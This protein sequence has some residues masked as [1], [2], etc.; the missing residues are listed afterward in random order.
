MRHPGGDRS[1]AEWIVKM[2]LAWTAV[3]CGSGDH[4][5]NTTIRTKRPDATREYENRMGK[6][7]NDIWPEEDLFVMHRLPFRHGIT[8]VENL[9]GDVEQVGVVGVGREADERDGLPLDLQP[10]DLTGQAGV[11]DPGL[12]QCGN[13][14]RATRGPVVE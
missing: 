3:D 14:L 12:P 1:L 5:M 8:H 11:R 2:E 9:G 7:V 10:R 6:K 4:P 13:G